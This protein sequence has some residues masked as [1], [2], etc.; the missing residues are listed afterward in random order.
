MTNTTTKAVTTEP[1]SLGTDHIEEIL[2]VAVQAKEDYNSIKPEDKFPAKIAKFMPTVRKAAG[3]IS[4]FSKAGPEVK[5]I[6]GDEI[7]KIADKYAPKFGVGGK[8]AVY[9]T[10]GANII[11]SGFKIFKAK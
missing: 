10:E 5:D 6:T 11:V 7:K 9:V 3:A 2:D 4:A 1:A 8:I